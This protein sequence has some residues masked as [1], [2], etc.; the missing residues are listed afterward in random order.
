MKLN[1]QV[2]NLELSQ[3]LEKL[4]VKQESLFQW[5]E[6]IRFDEMKSGE[7]KQSRPYWHLILFPHMK[8]EGEEKTVWYELSGKEMISAYTV[9]ELGEMLPWGIPYPKPST[10]Q[11]L[12]REKGGWIIHYS[13]KFSKIHQ[14]NADT[15]ANAR[16]KMLIYLL[17][18][19]L[20]TL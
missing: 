10:L 17:E 20:I 2:S 6:F 19:K 12:K 4:G 13:N 11:I 14:E 7:I 9:A 5:A 18:N 15:E 8:P 16:A 1:Q 3:K